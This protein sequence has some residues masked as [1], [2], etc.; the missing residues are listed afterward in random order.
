MSLNS[1]TGVKLPG[2]SLSRRAVIV[3]AA[4]AVGFLAS[5]SKGDGNSFETMLAEHLQATGAR[6]YG[7]YWCPHCEH[8][9]ELFGEAV[10]L[11]PYVE[12]DPE[13]EN[14][15]A[16]LCQEKEIAGYPTWEIN[17]EFYVGG[18]SLEELAQLSGFTEP[19]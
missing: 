4:I 18:R 11:V 17:G 7:A 6:M 10:E 19:E 14:S 9:K 1:E 15:Q 2:Y 5:C 16:Q 8:Q 3:A 12:C 13:G